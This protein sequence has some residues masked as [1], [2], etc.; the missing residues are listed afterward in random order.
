MY[1]VEQKTQN[2]IA[3]ILDVGRITV[4]RLLA[5]ARARNEVRITL[6]SPLAEITQLERE[7]ENQFDIG[8]VVVAPLSDPVA[9]PLPAISAA[10]GYYISGL[11]KSGMRVG[12][13][14]G[15]TLFN[16]IPFLSD[17]KLDNFTVVSLLG[18]ISEARKYNPTEFAWQFAKTF[19]GEGF[20]LPAPAIV[21]SAQTKKTLIENCGLNEI[22]Q[23]AETL[24]LAIVSVG[25]VTPTN[26]AYRVNLL[27]DQDRASLIENGAVGDLLFHYFDK[28]GVLLDHPIDARVMAADV[29]QILKTPMR[30]LSSGGPEKIDAL[31]GAI[32]LIRPTIFITDEQS[33]KTLLSKFASD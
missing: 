14:W 3:D 11:V 6:Q 5:E 12:V 10:T 26:L 25:N 29:A 17:R 8:S 18:G 16:S 21:D 7:L 13:G 33:A 9:D 32:K 31:Y 23:L 30:L 4:V 22:F 2:A 24:D 20:L 19:Q 1:Y 27:N 28:D 15:Q